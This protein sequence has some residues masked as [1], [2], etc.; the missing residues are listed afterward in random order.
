MKVNKKEKL[1]AKN[2]EGKYIPDSLIETH[3]TEISYKL[4]DTSL[5][6]KYFPSIYKNLPK[7]KPL[8]KH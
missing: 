6:E 1:T 7:G 3:V 8:F 4:L 2:W 5:L